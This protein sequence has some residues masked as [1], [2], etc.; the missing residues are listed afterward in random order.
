MV[1][2][3]AVRAEEYDRVYEI[4]EWQTDLERLRVLVPRLFARRRVLE[5]AC[6]TGYWTQY[7]ASTAL[8]VRATDVNEETLR[9]AR[10][11]CRALPNVEFRCADA[12]APSLDGACF[13]AGL[14][15]LWLSHVDVARL[16]EFVSAFHSHLVSGAVV[17]MFDERWLE[18]RR[19]PTSRID[20]RGNRYEPRKLLS[21]ERFEIIKNFYPPDRLRA[22]F[23]PSTADLAY[24]ER[25]RFWMMTYRVR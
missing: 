8:A 20:E 24:E 17:L 23:E 22:L 25:E 19:A 5:V 18:T 14:A 9:V 15:G 2:Y 12:Y 21:G 6:G 10:A 3:Y 1:H 11:R 4:P 13:D 7:A 16:T